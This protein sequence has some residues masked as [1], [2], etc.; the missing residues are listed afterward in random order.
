VAA[1]RRR[2]GLILEVGV[3]LAIIGVIWLVTSNSHSPY[4][5]SLGSILVTFRQTWLF[6]RFGSD[7]VP[8]LIRLAVGFSV[9]VV[10]GVV[11]GFVLAKVRVLRL[12]AR[13]IMAFLMAMP[14]PALLPVFIVFFGIGSLMKIAVIVSVCIWPVLYNA[15]DGLIGMEPTTADT[16]NAFRIRGLAR[17]RYVVLP[18]M[19]PRLFAGM[20]TSLSIAI[21]IL[22]VAEMVASDNG[23]G[24]FVLESEQSYAVT[25]MWAGILLL[26]I[27][28]YTLNGLLGLVERRV[29][30]WQLVP[31]E[32]D[33]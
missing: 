26:G 7:V 8:S 14:P 29:L 5:P 32:A 1:L 4:I 22:I 11:I 28:G 6:A 18:A 17:L 2:A 10:G 27:L 3:T 9:S 15:M 19:A 13:P 24:Y 25:A 33:L 31:L 21:L 30:R 12:M 16:A 20:R 23:I